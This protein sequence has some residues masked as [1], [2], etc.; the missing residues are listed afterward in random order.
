MK[1]ALFLQPGKL[2]DI[3]ITAPIAKYFFEK[4]YEIK[5]PVFENFYS[6]IERFDYVKPMTFNVGLSNQSYH[7]NKRMSFWE[8]GAVHSSEIKEHNTRNSAKSSLSF[9]EQFYSLYDKEDVFLI[10]PCFS[11][12][13]HTPQN[14]EK[15]TRNQHLVYKQNRNWIDLKYT[16]V[17]VPLKQ[18][19]NFSFLRDEEKEDNLLDFI[20]NFSKK[21]YGTEEYTLVHDYS[22]WKDKKDYNNAKNIINFTYVKGYTIFDWYK[23]IKNSSSIYCVD[24]SLCNFI[25]VVDDFK[26]IEKHYLGSE[27]PHYHF[28]M[29]NILYNNWNNLSKEK[30]ILY[31]DLRLGQI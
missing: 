6:T 21:K 23:V 29:R 12:P 26:E 10:D 17:D 9:F 3:I 15:F 2:G 13:G 28:Y 1:K 16:M 5:W 11:F 8:N 27:E 18:R 31:E 20:T 19:W 4:G 22:G 30:D 14:V 25:E 7:N 24:S